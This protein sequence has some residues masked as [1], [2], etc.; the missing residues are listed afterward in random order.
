M[1]KCGYVTRNIHKHILV[2]RYN[3]KDLH[4]LNIKKKKKHIAK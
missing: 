2:N 4:N 3:P 1:K